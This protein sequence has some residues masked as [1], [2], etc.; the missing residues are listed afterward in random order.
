MVDHIQTI[1]RIGITR[2]ENRT[3]KDIQD[4]QSAVI[5]LAKLAGFSVNVE[6]K[7]NEVTHM[8]GVNL[9]CEICEH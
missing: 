5:S 1:N 8:T 6:R 3:D 7:S 2:P 4:F 9:S